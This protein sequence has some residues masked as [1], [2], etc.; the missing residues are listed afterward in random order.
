MNQK[1]CENV[2]E[3]MNVAWQSAEIMGSAPPGVEKRLAIPLVEVPVP[4]IST[5]YLWPPPRSRS[6]FRVQPCTSRRERAGF[7]RIRSTNRA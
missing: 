7:E 4:F 1:I 6:S 3:R 5:G 2:V